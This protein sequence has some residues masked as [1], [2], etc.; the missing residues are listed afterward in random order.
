MPKIS[1]LTDITT[2]AVGDK[3][4]VLDVSD[5]GT[6]NPAGTVKYTT[7]AEIKTSVL[8]AGVDIGTDGTG[9]IVTTDGSQM[10]SNK[11]IS[12]ANIADATM[13]GT[14][15]IGDGSTLATPVLISPDING[16]TIDGAVIDDTTTL[17][18]IDSNSTSHNVAASTLIS[19]GL[20]QTLSNKTLI[21]PVMAS[22]APKAGVKL[23]FPDS[24]ASD[25]VASL[26]AKQT[27]TNKT[28]TTPVIASLRAVDQGGIISI[29]ASEGKDTVVL[30]DAEQTLTAKILTTPTITNP[31]VSGGTMTGVTIDSATSK[32]D[33]DTLSTVLG[34][35]TDL[36]AQSTYTCT[37]KLGNG[38]G[39]TDT[40]TAGEIFTAL[41]LTGINSTYYNIIANSVNMTLWIDKNTYE[42]VTVGG[43]VTAKMAVSGT[44]VNATMDSIAF[45]GLTA[46]EEYYLAVSF[47]TVKV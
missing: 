12:G 44:G 46:S 27:L 1:E 23:T 34:L 26:Q 14:T 35:K 41:N 29:P 31:V 21:D 16:G 40:V 2:L 45:A 15:T 9:N 36:D 22:L 25:T 18:L 6:P 38:S 39:T 3:I 19:A 10:L 47:R 5:T 42:Y 32:I 30:A 17:E 11:T 28:L 43:A 4:P 13:S 33:G 8:G 20:T 37:V 24:V 7:P